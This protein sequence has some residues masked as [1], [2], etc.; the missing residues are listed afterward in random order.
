MPPNNVSVIS[1]RVAV[2]EQAGV[3][4]PVTGTS[5]NASCLCTSSIPAHFISD[6]TQEKVMY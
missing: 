6:D 5:T 1:M 4:H 2:A 3:D